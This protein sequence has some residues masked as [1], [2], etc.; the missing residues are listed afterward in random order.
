MTV[1]KFLSFWSQHNTS[2]IEGLIALIIFFAL[3]L[4]YRSFFAKK[5]SH[6]EVSSENGLNA[7]ELEKTLQKILEAQSAI[8]KEN[9]AAAHD[10]APARVHHEPAA[11]A[12]APNAPE[13]EAEVAQLRLTLSESQK[14]IE[15]LQ[16]KL[17]SAEQKASEASSAAPAAAPAAEGI[18]AAEREE[19]NGKLR[20][21][22]A[23]LAEYEIISED[24]ADLSKYRDENDTLKKEIEALKAGGATSAAAAPS[25]EPVVEAPKVEAAATPAPAASDSAN[26]TQD[27]I[28]AAFAAAVENPPAA[29]EAVAEAMAANAPPLPAEDSSLIDDELMREFEAAVAG[30]KASLEDVANKAG[31]GT[32]EAK[33]DN[34]TDKLMNEFESFVTKKS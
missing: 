13:S 4:A 12:P 1:E 27:M 3:F 10:E 14:K 33:D 9:H 17:T 7:A 11:A 24:I 32:E 15:V 23:R 16:E 22:E 18:S 31:D 34:D 2:I 25:S 20:D 19:L 28:D 6:G 21:L 30:Q 26:A 8:A 5:E 29:E